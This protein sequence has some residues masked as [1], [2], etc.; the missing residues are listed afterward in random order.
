[1]RI[2]LVSAFRIVPLLV[3][4]AGSII[5]RAQAG[6]RS[7]HLFARL[8][9][10]IIMAP[11]G[12]RG[13]TL[14]TLYH[15]ID[16]PFCFR[17][18]AYLAERDIAFNSSLVER[19]T[20]PPELYGLNPLGK[21]PVWVTDAGKPVFGASTIM[22]FLDAT[23]PGAPL[24][25]ADALPRARCAMAEELATDGLLQPLIRLERELGGRPAETWNV[26]L[27]RTE[28]RKIRTMLQVFEQILGGR[29]WL[30][31]DA[32]TTADLALALPLT[33]LERFGL[34]LQGLPGLTA[35]AER[36]GKRPAIVAARTAQPAKPAA[37]ETDPLRRL[38][39]VPTGDAP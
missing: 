11:A 32:L 16:C 4:R 34:D 24:L 30:V 21:L 31:G 39:P 20:P 29:T 5:V 35:L 36:L 38:S 25:P 33:I 9:A 12:I 19:D 23:E 17:V 13:C 28:T 6:N 10:P 26:E 14:P 22:A 2:V 37:Q 3:Q 18:R 1:M 8:G 27:Y 15:F 7:A